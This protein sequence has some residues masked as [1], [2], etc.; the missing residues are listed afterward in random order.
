[1]LPTDNDCLRVS[2]FFTEE[3]MIYLLI[4][5]LRVM[6]DLFTQIGYMVF[7]DL[8]KFNTGI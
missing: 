8:P 1:M 6:V 4:N 5:L 3:L 2:V 7:F